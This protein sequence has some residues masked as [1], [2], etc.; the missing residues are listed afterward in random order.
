MTNRLW[1]NAGRASAV[2][3]L[4]V[5]LGGALS[6]QA[7]LLKHSG[8]KGADQAA[9]DA[10]A[11]GQQPHNDSYII[12][13]D[14]VLAIN[15]WKETEMS[16]SIPVRS[17]G[18]ISLPLVGEVQAAGQTP[19]QLEHA[20]EQKLVSYIAD[21]EVTVMV[22]QINSKKFNILGEV[23]KPGSYSLSLANSVVDAIAA[24]GGFRDFAK[25]NKV[26]VLRRN[27][28]GS[29]TRIPFNYKNFIKGRS[30]EG[31][32]RLQPNDTVIIP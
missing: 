7:Q 9:P 30:A 24:A 4:G 6:S 11:G 8:K 32:I 29:Q 16:R 19:L 26:Y 25:K 21:P 28:D 12:G 20:I 13:N 27:T 2:L 31:D 22:E 23:V 18:K 1:K 3:L 5:W 14:D 17:D 15:V 10:Q